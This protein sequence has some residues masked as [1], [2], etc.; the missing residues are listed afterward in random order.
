MIEPVKR[1]W[2]IRWKY[3]WSYSMNTKIR[4]QFIYGYIRQSQF[5]IKQVNNINNYKNKNDGKV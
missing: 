3:C 5:N 2:V 1:K 4:I